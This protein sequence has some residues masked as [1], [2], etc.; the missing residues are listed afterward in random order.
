MASACRLEHT[1]AQT[2]WRALLACKD[3]LQSSEG[4]ESAGVYFIRSDAGDGA[5]QFS[6]S[7][8]GDRNVLAIPLRAQGARF[9]TG[10]DCFD[11]FSHTLSPRAEGSRRRNRLL[12]KFV[13]EKHG[14]KNL[15]EEWWHFTLKNEPYPK[16]YFDVPI[17]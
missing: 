15:A 11:P 12:L 14:F 1:A 13:M 4:A 3:Y 5:W 2:A 6:G 17:E 7:E 9:A 8:R 10:Y 16:T